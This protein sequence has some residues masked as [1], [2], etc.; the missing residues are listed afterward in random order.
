[1]GT[2]VPAKHGAPLSRS[3]LTQMIP[4]SGWPGWMRSPSKSS[5]VSGVPGLARL[6]AV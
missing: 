3:G 4:K 2:R 6:D 1:M 5:G